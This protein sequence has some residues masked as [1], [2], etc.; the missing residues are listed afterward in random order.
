MTSFG[1]GMPGLN[2]RVLHLLRS[3][4]QGDKVNRVS[5]DLRSV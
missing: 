2:L 5:P 1:K 4:K 3:V